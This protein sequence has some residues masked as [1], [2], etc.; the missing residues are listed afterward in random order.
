[1]VTCNRVGQD[2][3]DELTGEYCGGSQICTPTGDD[4]VKLDDTVALATAEIKINDAG[5]KKVIGVN[6]NDE[7]RMISD[8]LE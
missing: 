8:L 3:T 6:L 4:L 1:M 5:P 7:I 2:V